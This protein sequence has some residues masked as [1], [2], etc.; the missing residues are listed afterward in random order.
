MEKL[1]LDALKAISR[2][3]GGFTNNSIRQQVWPCILRKQSSTRKSEKK[4]EDDNYQASTA[5]APLQ[6]KVP[7]RKPSGAKKL[8][9]KE[10]DIWE[11]F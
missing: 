3:P 6:K 8:T 7:A 4:E 9:S 11:D 2:K 1:D 5:A 10:K